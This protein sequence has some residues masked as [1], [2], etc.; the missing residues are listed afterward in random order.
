MV[1]YVILGIVQGLT[2]FLP[3][4][5]SGH[6]AILQH[7]FGITQHAVQ[8]DIVLHLGTTV[9]LLIF[10]SQDLIRLF[11]DMR[12]ILLIMLAT[13]VTGVIAIAGKDFFES[14]FSSP[15]YLWFGFIVTGCLLLATQP[16]MKGTRKNIT[17]VDVLIMGVAQAVAIVP[18]I[19]RSGA[20][21]AS[22]LFR[23]V[24]RQESF[25]FSF[26][27]AIPAV[28]GATL[29]EARH[30]TANATASIGIPALVTGF[31]CSMVTGLLSL[32]LLKQVI[33]KAKLHYFSYYCFALAIVVL[34][35]IR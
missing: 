21:V 23:G 28:I 34:L 6:L 35:F 19:S 26:I 16:F 13:A 3:V 27:A 14:L 9:A 17:V 33:Q 1:Q 24:E 22:L 30:I 32:W 25:R 20:T 7:I 2:E 18:S 29:L 4:S 11:K 15:K 5:S 8:L 12:S 10:F 31:I